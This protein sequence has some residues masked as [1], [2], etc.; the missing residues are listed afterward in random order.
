MF[1]NVT[2]KVL[3][4]NRQITDSTDYLVIHGSKIK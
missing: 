3:N 2:M 1:L 4:Q